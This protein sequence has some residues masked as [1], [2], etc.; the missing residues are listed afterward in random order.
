MK[1]ILKSINLHEKRRII[2]FN[3]IDRVEQSIA[4][5]VQHRFNAMSVSCTKNIGIERLVA[6][7][8]RALNENAD[9][10]STHYKENIAN[11]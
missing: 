1:S 6:Y 8:E 2:V 4:E 5:N 7:I 10:T 9:P 11:A 3:K